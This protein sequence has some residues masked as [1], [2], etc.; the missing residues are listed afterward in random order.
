MLHIL[1]K[2]MSLECPKFETKNLSKCVHISK[3]KRGETQI[4]SVDLQLYVCYPGLGCHLM[5]GHT[6]TRFVHFIRLNFTDPFNIF[7]MSDCKKGS[8]LIQ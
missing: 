1:S 3:C 6:T 5:P 4:A 7:Y 8:L 2:M